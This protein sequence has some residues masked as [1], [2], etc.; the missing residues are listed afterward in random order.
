MVSSE[1]CISVVGFVGIELSAEC[2]DGCCEMGVWCG[3]VG[4]V[5]EGGVGCGGSDGMCDVAVCRCVGVGVSWLVCFIYSHPSR[6]SLSI[7]DM[8][9]FECFVC[10]SSITVSDF[11]CFL[12]SLSLEVSLSDVDMSESICF[13]CL[14]NISVTDF[15]CCLCS[16]SLGVSL[17]NV[18]MS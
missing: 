17:S 13:M 7:I 10:L 2:V 11:V 16:L 3:G 6:V 9:A 1:W 15:V 18:D 4:D 8:S 14:S 12:C 5:G